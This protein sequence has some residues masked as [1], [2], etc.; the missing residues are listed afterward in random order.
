MGL[1]QKQVLEFC[2]QLLNHPIGDNEYESAMISRLAVL[3]IR[4][5][6]KWIDTE[7]YT[8]KYSAVIKLARL[9]VVEKAYQTK[10][11]EDSIPGQRKVSSIYRLVNKAVDKYMTIAHGGRDPTPIY[12]IYYTRSYSFKIRYTT[13]A[14]ANIQWI[15][16]EI[17]Y[18]KIRFHVSQVRRM[19][20]GLVQE[21]RE[22][23]FN[24]LMMV[25]I[26]REGEVG[27]KYP[28]IDWDHIVDQL[29]ETRVGWA[30]L[31]DERNQFAVDEKWWLFQR[32][33]QEVQLKEKFI[34]QEGK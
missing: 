9:I 31:E 30:F 6:N 21:A 7:D 5:D 34:D 27:E 32:V 29:S 12:W 26:D 15:G 18:P 17:L 4:E 28:P 25:G 20:H 24:E 33:F 2:I 8:P 19:M 13:V 23:L 10:K 16:D 1:I 11:G 14:Q 3:G 22:L